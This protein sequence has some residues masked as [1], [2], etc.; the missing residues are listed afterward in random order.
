MLNIGATTEYDGYI[1]RIKSGYINNSQDQAF[2][3]TMDGQCQTLPLA[4][5][6]FSQQCP[7]DRNRAY[8]GGLLEGQRMGQSL[9]LYK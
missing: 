7:E 2:D 1:S 3:D 9:S 4:F 6:E 8:I 5:E